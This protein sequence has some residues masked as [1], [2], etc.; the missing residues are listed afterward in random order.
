MR[1]AGQ[2]IRHHIRRNG[3]TRGLLGQEE[4]RGGSCGTGA[5]VE[6]AKEVSGQFGPSSFKQLPHEIPATLLVG[7]LN[8]FFQQF[9]WRFRHRQ[10]LP[11]LR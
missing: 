3:S 2:G 9:L 4:R 7:F 11:T 10:C 6:Q 1:K 5:G 8:E